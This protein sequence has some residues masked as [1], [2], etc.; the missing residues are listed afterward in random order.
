MTCLPKPN[1]NLR[2]KVLF[3]SPKIPFGKSIYL[4]IK[5][6]WCMARHF[7]K[8]LRRLV[9]SDLACVSQV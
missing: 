5:M 4:N 9:Y 8:L 1:I 3:D 7:L 6:P 2:Y